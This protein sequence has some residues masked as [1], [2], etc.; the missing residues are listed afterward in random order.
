LILLYVQKLMKVADNWHQIKHDKLKLDSI[1]RLMICS[2]TPLHESWIRLIKR[3]AHSFLL[4]IHESVKHYYCIPESRFKFIPSQFMNNECTLVTIRM[5]ILSF[6]KAMRQCLVL[7][8]NNMNICLKLLIMLT[9][10]LKI[11]V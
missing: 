6:H 3:Q 7:I 10:A 2:Q 4:A 1:I 11:Y 8:P 9:Y 5:Q